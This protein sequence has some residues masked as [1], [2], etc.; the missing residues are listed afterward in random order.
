MVQLLGPLHRG[1]ESQ[2]GEVTCGGSPY[3][4]CK[5][6]EIKM[7][8]YM[9]RRVIPPKRVTS[10]TWGP[11]PPCKQALRCG[12]ARSARI[13]GK[14]QKHNHKERLN[15]I[16]FHFP[17]CNLV[18]RVISPASFSRQEREPW[19]R[20]CL[21]MTPCAATTAKYPK[22]RLGARRRWICVSLCRINLGQFTW[23][24]ISNLRTCFI[25][26]F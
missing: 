1:G 18:P 11:P 24:N 9:D 25:W 17:P 4:W 19:E 13:M 12:L 3:L 10:L 15:V 2:I 6:D 20:D 7:R 23:Y 21:P 26:N 16:S 8:D 22:K 5:R 14:R